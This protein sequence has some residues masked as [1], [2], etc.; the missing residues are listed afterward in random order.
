MPR[1]GRFE[2][3]HSPQTEP[4]RSEV[5][6]SL[7]HLFWAKRPHGTSWQTR[8]AEAG[9]R[10]R[11]M[12]QAGVSFLYILFANHIIACVW[13][14]PPATAGRRTGSPRTAAPPYSS[15]GRLWGSFTREVRILD[16]SF[17]G[18][19]VHSQSSWTSPF[20]SGRSDSMCLDAW[21]LPF[22][23]KSLHPVEGTLQV[24]QGS[25]DA[26]V[27]SDDFL[28]AGIAHPAHIPGLPRFE[29]SFLD[30]SVASGLWPTSRVGRVG[31]VPHP[32]LPGV[33]RGRPSPNPPP[34]EGLCPVVFRI[35]TSWP[36]FGL[37][38][39]GSRLVQALA[40]H[41]GSCFAWSVEEAPRGRRRRQ[42]LRLRQRRR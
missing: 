26:P 21:G 38:H 17:E 3:G 5:Y 32:N 31:L 40:H 30:R 27:P 15:R 25:L 1:S 8:A 2:N 23:G 14:S 41:V 29:S 19:D 34:Q 20:N 42:Q 4:R 9:G 28:E 16:G 6:S 39:A 7:S 36:S 11:A 18:F 13:H 22:L 12:A 35:L 24:Q 37:S 33:C 10:P